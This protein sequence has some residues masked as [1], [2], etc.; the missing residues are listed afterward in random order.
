MY[1][2]FNIAQVQQSQQCSRQIKSKRRKKAYVQ[3]SMMNAPLDRG[4]DDDSGDAA[5]YREDDIRDHYLYAA[6]M[7]GGDGEVGKIEMV[8]DMMKDMARRSDGRE[9]LRLQFAVAKV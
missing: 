5:N 4:R 7:A 8:V 2:A 9:L 1:A 3:R 6:T